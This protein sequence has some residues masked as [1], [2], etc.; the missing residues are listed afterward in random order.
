MLSHLIR[1]NPL[2]NSWNDNAVQR[3]EQKGAAA[4]PMDKYD[5]SKTL[6]ERATLEFLAQTKV[7]FDVVRVLPSTVFGVRDIAR[8][9]LASS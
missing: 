1:P 4:D 8:C 7:S 9:V 2:Q 5:A 6:S 3:I